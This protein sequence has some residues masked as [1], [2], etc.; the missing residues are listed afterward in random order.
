MSLECFTCDYVNAD[1]NYLESL[2]KKYSPKNFNK[3]MD[4]VREEREKELIKSIDF[5]LKDKN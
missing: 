3:L 2:S 5:L 1:I 4:I